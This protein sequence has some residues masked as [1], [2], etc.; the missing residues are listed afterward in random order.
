MSSYQLQRSVRMTNSYYQQAV[1][2][3]IYEYINLFNKHLSSQ[4]RIAD[5]EQRETV[6]LV[7]LCHNTPEQAVQ[8]IILLRNKLLQPSGGSARASSEGQDLK[9]VVDAELR[10]QLWRDTVTE[11][12]LT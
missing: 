1:L 7:L 12:F 4:Y 3:K 8:D 9:A 2:Y 11:F 6:N 10:L 5:A